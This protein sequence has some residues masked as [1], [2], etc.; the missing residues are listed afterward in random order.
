VSLDGR[1]S[2][3]YG[4]KSEVSIGNCLESMGISLLSELDILVFIYRHGPTLTTT[5]QIARLIGYE[6]T[7]VVAA[8]DRLESQELIERVGSPQGAHLHRTL[9][10]V[11]AERRRCIRQLVSL[12][13]SRAGRLLLKKLLMPVRLEPRQE[14]QSP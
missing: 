12:S 1:L 5:S 13:E 6:N 4:T 11:G 3:Q 7:V 9:V 2:T 8:L 14:A 10:S